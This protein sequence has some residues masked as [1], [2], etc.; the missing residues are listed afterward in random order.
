MALSRRWTV[1][2]LMD[3][4]MAQAN[5]QDQ[6]AYA[7]RHDLVNLVMQRVVDQFYSLMVQA[8]MTPAIL[9]P[10]TTAKYATDA[11]SSF[12]AAT[13][14]LTAADISSN[15][16]AGDVGKIIVWRKSTTVSIGYIESITST[17]AVVVVG[18]NLPSSDQATID[19]V[20]VVPTAPSENYVSLTGLTLMRMGMPIKL[21]MESSVAT[22]IEPV[23]LE[24]YRNFRTAAPQNRNKIVWA[25]DGDQIL[26]K[27]GA[28]LSTYGTLTLRYPRVPTLV[29]ADSD[30]IDL[31]D[32]VAIVLA[33]ELLKRELLRRF[34]NLEPN[35]ED[36]RAIVQDMFRTFQGAVQTEE[37]DEKVKALA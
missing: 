16:V 31:P 9:T 3:H 13:R 10:D 33:L 19:D 5:V 15:F 23:S 25:Y 12:T 14:T 1:A 29:V 26:L 32:G 6:V 37:I 36:L 7:Q 4:A 34:K 24:G 27:K 35:L 18:D 8:Y 22:A 17:L 2:K 30:Y 21:E 20:L 11:T 28:S